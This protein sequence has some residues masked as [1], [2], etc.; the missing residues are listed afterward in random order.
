MNAAAVDTTL[1]IDL[2]HE[3]RPRS[4]ARGAEAFLRAN[5]HM[6]LFVPCVVLGEY[7]EG[8][9]DPEST[10][11]QALVAP[12]QVLDIDAAVARLYGKTARQLRTRGELIGAN[13]LWIAC[14]A[15]AAG[16]PIV[17]RNVEHFRRVPGL[18]VLTYAP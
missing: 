12:L 17:T 5:A 1:L 14:T 4:R 7:L 6:E 2:Q 10:E 9:D 8:F 3:R 15:Q 11:A 18:Q 13:D 16:L